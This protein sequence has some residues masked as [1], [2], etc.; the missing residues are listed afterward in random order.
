MLLIIS[1]SLRCSTNL[2]SFNC[3]NWDQLKALSWKVDS[4]IDRN[5]VPEGLCVLTG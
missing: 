2:Q 3:L 5:E 1:D 4:F